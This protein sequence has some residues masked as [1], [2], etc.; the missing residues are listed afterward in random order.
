MN[1]THKFKDLCFKYE[2][3]KMKS[4]FKENLFLQEF[5][6]LLHIQTKEKSTYCKIILDS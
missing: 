2:N 4:T 6:Q 1:K 5:Q 3:W